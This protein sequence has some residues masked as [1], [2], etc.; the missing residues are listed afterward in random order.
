VKSGRRDCRRW[1]VQLAQG[2]GGWCL[3]VG[4]GFEQYSP[5]FRSNYFTEMWSGSKED[6]YSRHIDCCVTQL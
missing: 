6:T 1:H 3:G 4:F 5:Q 2:L